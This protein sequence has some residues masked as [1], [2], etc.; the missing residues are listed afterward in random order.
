MNVSQMYRQLLSQGYSAQEADDIVE[1]ELE[2]E[3]I[4]R[5]EEMAEK[6]YEEKQNEVL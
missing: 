6:L 2:F 5:E 3:R 4:V 1:E